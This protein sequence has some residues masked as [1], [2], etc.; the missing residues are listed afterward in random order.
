M[1][2]Y[3]YLVTHMPKHVSQFT[4]SDCHGGYRFYSWPKRDNWK[5]G[6]QQFWKIPMN[7]DYPRVFLPHS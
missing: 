1:D 6:I 3:I 4:F 2:V 7:P 5:L